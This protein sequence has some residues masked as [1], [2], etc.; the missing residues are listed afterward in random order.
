L[1]VSP[2]LVQFASRER[3]LLEHAAQK[4]PVPPGAMLELLDAVG[5]PLWSAVAGDSAPLAATNVSRVLAEI[6][7]RVEGVRCGSLRLRFSGA[8]G[9]PLDQESLRVLETIG[10][11]LE[12]CLRREVELDGL[13]EEHVATANQLIAIYNVTRKT[14]EQW[15]LEAK[16]GAILDEAVRVTGS[17][18]GFLSLGEGDDRLVLGARDGR[19]RELGA[20]LLADVEQHD[21]G[22]VKLLDPF[23]FVG[24]EAP[25][26]CCVAA[27]FPVGET[28]R[29]WILLTTHGEPFT[30][31]D[32][33]LLESIADLAGGF[34]QTAR[35]H[36]RLMESVKTQREME[37]AESIQRSLVPERFDAGQLG[38]ELAGVDL[39]AACRS[40]SRVGGDFYLVKP[41]SDGSVLFALGDV[42]GKGVSAGI[43]MSMIRTGVLALNQVETS[44][45]RI[46]E[47]LNRYLLP[48]LEC[49]TKFV[50]LFVARYFPRW[51]RLDFA[52]AGHA[53]VAHVSR[54]KGAVELPADATPIG[55]F[56]DLEVP[57]HSLVLGDGDAF[58][59]LSDGY[60][61]ATSPEGR[62]LGTGA[63]LAELEELRP[64]S[65]REIVEALASR[66]RE[67]GEGA[68]PADDQTV[69]VLKRE[70]SP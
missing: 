2:S 18:A 11:L 63:L 55:I 50:T 61:D 23:Q 35:L 48:E 5:T 22:R 67:H 31:G 59:V 53:P 57:S 38:S 29:G 64:R 7:L 34:V 6:D 19:E 1:A 26:T 70:E 40:A 37:I 45:A 41:A 25:P 8:D 65:A 10:E 16:L 33:K 66:A 56:E 28:L 12:G 49:A 32:L 9:S 14:R 27:P 44:P 46:L 54:E 21:R 58:C 17:T 42:S 47:E 4:L 68:P 69:V 24:H 43:L 13:V 36:D 30:A 52:N 3:V 39:S 51:G 15:Q 62:R 20:E 60:P